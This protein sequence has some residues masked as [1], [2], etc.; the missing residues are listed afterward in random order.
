MQYPNLCLYL[1]D[2]TIV[3][4]FI[5]IYCLSSSICALQHHRHGLFQFQTKIVRG[6]N[7]CCG[8]RCATITGLSLYGKKAHYFI[9]FLTV[10][11]IYGSSVFD[12]FV[13]HVLKSKVKMI[14]WG[15]WYGVKQALFIIGCSNQWWRHRSWYHMP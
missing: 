10:P 11:L 2:R 9:S 7:W 15:T 6:K 14:S 3:G 4:L 12:I 5:H 8:I 1:V 13:F